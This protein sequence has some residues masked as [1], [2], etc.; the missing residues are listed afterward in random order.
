[1]IRFVLSV[2]SVNLYNDQTRCFVDR[3]GKYFSSLVEGAAL[4]MKVAGFDTGGANGANFG[5]GCRVVA[6]DHAVPAFGND[7][8]VAHDDSTER[9]TFTGFAAPGRQFDGAGEEIIVV[10][11]RLRTP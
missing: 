3:M 4:Q 8:A 7:L 10:M 1:M 5:V 9:A 2:I 6:G 11:H